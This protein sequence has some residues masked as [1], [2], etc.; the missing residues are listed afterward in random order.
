MT[1]GAPPTS[2][3]ALDTALAAVLA[4]LGTAPPRTGS[5]IVTVYG[6]AILPRGGSLAL[7][8][9]LTLTRRLGAPE[10]V[11]RTAV[12]RLA[13]N[14]LLHGRRTG[15]R[16]AYALTERGETEFRAA[17]P[18]IYGGPDPA[19]DGR[20]RLAFPTPGA[21]RAALEAAGYASLV[22]GVML[23][24]AATP[25]DIPVLEAAGPPATLQ[26]LAARTW[27]LARLADDYAQFSTL[28]APLSPVPPADPLDAMAARTLLIHAWRRIALRDPHLPPALLPPDWPGAA[29]RHL[30]T[31]LYSA[32]AAGSEAWLDRASSGDGE[33]PAGPDPRGRWR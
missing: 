2:W 25:T 20:L 13:R 23:S 12:S 31:T 6:D 5:V 14:G 3:P 18:R 22:P 24:P 27:P 7:S 8:D 33:L 15:R 9:L 16:S 1:P 4:A 10:G 17:I 28:M 32:L 21:D 30:C 19:W 26:R 29:A 11:V